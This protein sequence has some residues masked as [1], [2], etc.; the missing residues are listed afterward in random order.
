[1]GIS[2]YVTISNNHCRL[3]ALFPNL[4]ASNRDG[5]TNISSDAETPSLNPYA[6]P[7]TVFDTPRFHQVPIRA[8]WLC[9][10]ILVQAF[11]IFMS[12]V[13]E[14]Y[15]HQSIVVS[16]PIFSLFGLA[17][18]ILA[19]R[20][21]DRAAVAFGGSAIFFASLIVFLINFNSWTPTQGN[22]PITILLF[23]YAAFALPTSAWLAFAMTKSAG[24]YT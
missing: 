5:A 17:I 9:R 10:L 20:N 22:G 7:A 1:V 8:G 21:R 23:V 4:I 19:L 2:Q 11:V 16:G 14:T 13:V 18:T 12:L 6:P 24:N 15:H 3:I